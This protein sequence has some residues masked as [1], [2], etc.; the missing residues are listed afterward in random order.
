[1]TPHK[2]CCAGEDPVLRLP[3]FPIVSLQLRPTLRERAGP[4]P[5]S[6][7]P[8]LPLSCCSAPPPHLAQPCRG[9]GG[10]RTVMG[11]QGWLPP[12]LDAGAREWR[13]SWPRHL[14]WFRASSRASSPAVSP[15][16]REEAA[17]GGR[18]PAA[19]WRSPAPVAPREG[20]W[21]STCRSQLGQVGTWTAASR[22]L[23]SGGRGLAGNLPHRPPCGFGEGTP[24]RQAYAS[25]W[26]K[27]V[28]WAAQAST[29]HTP[30]LVLSEPG[31]GPPSTH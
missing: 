16:E 18:L 13:L 20:C 19:W 24:A 8:P 3:A 1:M 4:L 15:A 5:C 26:D 21:S 22:P 23:P 30:K 2:C 10:G 9:R 25:G 6:S 31:A 11:S 28:V 12:P 14:G 29:V 17:A 7:L 27:P